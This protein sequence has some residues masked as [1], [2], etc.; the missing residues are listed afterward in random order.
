MAPPFDTALLSQPLMTAP[1]TLNATL[2]V[3]LTQASKL[4]PVLPTVILGIHKSVTPSTEND[5]SAELL[6]ALYLESP[7]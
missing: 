2:P 7:L 3:V 1:S 6:E 5:E 4:L